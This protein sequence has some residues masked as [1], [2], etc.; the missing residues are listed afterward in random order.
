MDFKLNDEQE[1]L[2]SGLTRFLATRYDLEKSR[3]AAKTGLG[4]QPEIWRA[5]AEELGILGAALP[6]ENGGIGGGPVEM[7]LIAEA[8]GHALVVEPY[9]DTAVVAAGLL[10]RAGGGTATALLEEIV[11]GTA[12]V[13]LAATEPT[14]GEFWQDVTTS[15]TRDGDSWVLRGQKIVSASTPLASHV[16]VTAR[17]SGERADADGISLFLVELG[18]A[19]TDI[20][21]HHYRTVDDRR[22]SDIA[23]DG[24]RLPTTALLG[25]EGGAWPSIALARDEGAAAICAEAVGGMRK[26]LADTVEYCKQRQQFGQSIG[27]FQVLQHRMVDMYMEVEQ[28][29]AAVLLAVL[30]LD[31]DDVTRARAVSAAKA[32]VGRAAQFVGQQAVQLHG[33]MGMTEELAIGH[34]FKRLTALQFEFGSTDHHVTRYARL[35]NR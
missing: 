18:S 9:V 10:L 2:R 1:L 34:Y 24:L 17:T 23:L 29:A 35:T 7:M 28:S 30:K 6:E 16:L 15:A 20:T 11:A 22:A 14:S 19:A 33:G 12:I 8:L 21:L 31:S 32:T 25:A 5:F 3:A 27:S 26:V 13:S 4:W